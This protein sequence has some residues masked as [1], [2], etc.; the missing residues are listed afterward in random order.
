[1]RGVDVDECYHW[2]G[3]VRF[4]EGTGLHK[5]PHYST[6]RIYSITLILC[7]VAPRHEDVNGSVTAARAQNPSEGLPL[8]SEPE[9]TLKRLWL[10][11]P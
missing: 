6:I 9:R 5:V 8:H 11:S 1:M 7:N 3:T 4:F 2:P 10:I